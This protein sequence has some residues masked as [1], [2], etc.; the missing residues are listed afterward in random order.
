[1]SNNLNTQNAAGRFARLAV[2]VV[3]FF[4]ALLFVPII[5]S[6]IYRM[7]GSTD[8]GMQGTLDFIIVCAIVFFFAIY[9][10]YFD[11]KRRLN[12]NKEQNDSSDQ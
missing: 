10:F 1:M 6:P 8:I 7:V 3:I 11:V 4:G 2:A 5:T 12:S 9:P